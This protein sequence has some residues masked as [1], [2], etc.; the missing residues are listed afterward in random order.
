MQD[1]TA[2]GRHVLFVRPEKE[3]MAGLWL[4]PVNGEPPVPLGLSMVGIRN[5][6]VHPG[7]RRITFTAGMPGSEV[8]ALAN[9]LPEPEARR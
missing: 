1:W 3:R 7:G 2:D 6:S 9:F 8:W 4:A 5:A